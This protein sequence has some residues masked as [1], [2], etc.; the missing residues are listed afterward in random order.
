MDVLRQI[1]D[2]VCR[3]GSTPGPELLESL[4]KHQALSL[5]DLPPEVRRQTVE[6]RRLA[7]SVLA[8][9]DEHV[10]ALRRLTADGDGRELVETVQRVWPGPASRRPDR[11]ARERHDASSGLSSLG[12]LREPSDGAP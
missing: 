1:A 2:H 6:T 11:T 3:K 10:A 4:L 9:E 7:D 8:R 12:P 5:E